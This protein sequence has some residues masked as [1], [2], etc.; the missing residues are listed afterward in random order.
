MRSEKKER[1]MREIDK[2]K[3]EEREKT[4]CDMERIKRG[5]VEKKREGSEEAKKKMCEEKA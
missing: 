2:T 5:L 1:M 3:V 4:G